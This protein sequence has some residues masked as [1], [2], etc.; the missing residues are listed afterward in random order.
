MK[1]IE[2]LRWSFF[3]GLMPGYGIFCDKHDIENEAKKNPTFVYMNKDKALEATAFVKVVD[4]YLCEAVLTIYGEIV[5]SF[6]D[7][8]VFF[9]VFAID[10]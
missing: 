5:A 8:N 7:D 4:M 10:E 1:A 6:K 9:Y 3:M 2:I